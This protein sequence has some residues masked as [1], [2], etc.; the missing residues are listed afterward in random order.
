MATLIKIKQVNGLQTALNAKA[1]SGANTDIT[2][3]YLNNT[4]LKIKDTNASHGLIVSPGSDITADR[5]LT[6][7][8]GDSN[9]T[10]TLNGDTTLTG[11]NTGDQTITL[12]GDVTGSGTGSFAATIANDAVTYA[13][14]QNISATSRILGR[15][16][17]S[18][19][20]TE[21]CTLSEV[22]DF[23]GSAAQ[24]DILYRG[25]SAWARLAAGVSGQ[26]L[27]TQGAAANPVWDTAVGV[28]TD[29]DKGDITVSASGLTWTIDNTAV[30]F[31][32][33]QN[34]ATSRLL[35]RTT[36]SSGSIE[37][38]TV[39]NGLTL[40]GGSLAAD[41]ASATVDG[42]VELATAAETT[43]G[44]DGTR[45]VTPDGLA[46]S[47][48]GKRTI[49][50]LVS[51]PLGSAI[52]TGDGKAFALIPST[53]NGWN[54]VAVAANVS[55]VSSSGI[56]TMQL[57]RSRRSSATART[58]A[59]MLSTKLTIDASEFESADAAAAAVINTSN[60]DVQTGDMIFVDIDV[61]G[62]GAKGLFVAMIFQLP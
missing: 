57:R 6:I 13:K 14:I 17:A 3:V 43:T 18:A 5:T 52:T 62:T 44:T 32:K 29:G 59:D 24:G 51:D 19:G 16:T 42:V 10:I 60:D 26:F 34:I 53:M 31:A 40:S 4:G 1:A 46:G 15:K 56:P 58:D 38:L 45:A 54:L 30:T 23:I 41:T 9:R 47:D 8:T 39:G 35:G 55:T 20:D 27:K 50:I 2:S 12:T 21:E 61:A 28:L 37:E 25:S 33:I 7:T 22:L 11:T 36:A 49:G 48:Y